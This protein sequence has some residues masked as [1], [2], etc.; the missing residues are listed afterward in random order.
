MQHVKDPIKTLR[1]LRCCISDDGYVIFRQ[2]DE[3][4]YITYGDNDLLKKI[5]ERYLKAPG[6]DD[7]FIGR[8]MPHYL[9]STGYKD[10]KVFGTFITTSGMDYDERMN[11]YKMRFSLRTMYYKKELEKDPYSI[12]AKNELEWMTYALE[13][14]QEVFGDPAFWYGETM[15]VSVA[16]K[17]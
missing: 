15:L 6:I 4:T 12:T 11:L 10:V 9:E 16:K 1:N 7:R 8:K 13:K 14:L 5:C 2:S 3:G 17:K